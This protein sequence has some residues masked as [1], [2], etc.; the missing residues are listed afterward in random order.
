[1]ITKLLLISAAFTIP[2]FCADWNS[3]A[4]AKYL[5]ARQ[6]AW[7]EWPTAKA[8]GGACVSC[9]TGL[10]YLLSRRA[11]TQDLHETAPTKW[12]TDLMA[13]MRSRVMTEETKPSTQTSVESVFLCFL[14][15][16]SDARNKSL[17][18]ETEQAF[19]KL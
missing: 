17:R 15:A 19:Q 6:K 8:T 10:P 13:G 9:H 18:P 1:M 3:S 7:S 5:D 16:L 11:L 4:A 2:T 14:D 12:E